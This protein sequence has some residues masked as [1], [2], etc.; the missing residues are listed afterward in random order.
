[1]SEWVNVD[2]GVR[3]G[4][5]DLAVD[6]KNLGLGIPIGNRKI[7]ILLYADDIALLTKNESD[8]QKIL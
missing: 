7:N 2:I 4:F 1:M 3:Q 5:N 8:L 6:I